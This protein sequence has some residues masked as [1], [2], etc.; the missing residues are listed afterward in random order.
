[1][2]TKCLFKITDYRVVKHSSD[3][4]LWIVH[5]VI[6]ILNKWNTL[7][8]IL[9]KPAV[10]LLGEAEDSRDLEAHIRLVCKNKA[11]SWMEKCD[12]A[13]GTNHHSNQSEWTGGACWCR[14]N[15]GDVTIRHWNLSY[16]FWEEN[17]MRSAPWA[18]IPVWLRLILHLIFHLND[19]FDQRESESKD[20][21]FNSQTEGV[22]FILNIFLSKL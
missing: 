13:A 19:T 17:Q 1:M 7:S 11:N 5:L 3:H 22:Y 16:C 8:F 18:E 15:R 14:H 6:C 4:K 9:G 10:L 21:R 20:R 12:T 2:K